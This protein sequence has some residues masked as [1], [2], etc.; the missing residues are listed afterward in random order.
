MPNLDHL[1][2]SSVSSYLTC[3]RAW[4]YHYVDRI[5][6]PTAPAL[7]FGSAFHNTVETYLT[8]DE[9]MTALWPK[10]WSAQLESER[11]VDW[12]K[13]SAEGLAATGLRMV[14]AESVKELADQVK[15]EFEPGNATCDIERRVELHVPGVPV[16]IVGYID[17]IT[18]D[19]VPGDFKT[20]ARMWT[21]A[22]ASNSMQSLFYLA[23]LNQAGVEVPSWKF[24][25][26]VFTK[27]SKPTARMFEV[28]H[29][30]GEL[31]WLFGLIAEVWRGI[32]A[33]IYPP[34]PDTWKCSPRYCDYWDRCR[35]K[36]V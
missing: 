16:P 1:S 18:R 10:Q 30:P 36:Y 4:K 29:K 8:A 15:G 33:E 35:G 5:P 31:F 7:V 17:V 14:T 9:P 11:T 3:A 20:A 24:R 23:A 21:D 12:G 13:Q 28:A 27:A 34:N 19:G 6:R 25:H 2:Y 32:E 26:Y 22:K